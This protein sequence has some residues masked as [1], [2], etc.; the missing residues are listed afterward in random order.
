MNSELTKVFAYGETMIRVVGAPDAP[1]FV[2]KDVCQALNLS[3]TSKAV[4]GLPDDERGITSSYTPGNAETGSG[5]GMQEML[6]VTEPGLYRLIFRSDK[7]EAKRFQ[8][9]VFKEVLPSIRATGGYGITDGTRLWT[10]FAQAK[11]G[12][13][14]L[15]LLNAM[16]IGA[17]AAR[18]EMGYEVNVEEFWHRVADGIKSGKIKNAFRLKKKSDG[19]ELFILPE[20]IIEKVGDVTPS[21]SELYKA[22]ACGHDWIAGDHRMRFT[23]EVSACWCIRVTTDPVL[24]ELCQF[25][26]T[27]EGVLAK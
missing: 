21:R 27:I 13:V 11:T 4:E 25:L 19:W 7:P 23:N 22:L 15:A 16:G 1:Q 14:Q 2:A 3:N 9:W 5:R 26:E 6:T 24:R 8:D 17:Q 20:P 12:R 10:A 18:A